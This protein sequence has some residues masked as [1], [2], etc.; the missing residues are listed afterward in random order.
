MEMILETNR[1]RNLV[2]DFLKHDAILREL[3]QKATRE[4][5]YYLPQPKICYYYCQDDET[6]HA[7]HVFPAL[8]LALLEQLS[9]LKKKKLR[10]I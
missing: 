3:V 5:E 10:T 1:L 8:T 2:Q 6:G 7:V 4:I 9:D